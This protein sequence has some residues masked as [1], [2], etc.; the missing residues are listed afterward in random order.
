MYD[1][2]KHNDF[3]IFLTYN[4]YGIM[5]WLMFY[6]NDLMIDNNVTQ[7]TICPINLKKITEDCYT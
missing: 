3:I 7:I 1:N 5:L 6:N 4:Y 2:D